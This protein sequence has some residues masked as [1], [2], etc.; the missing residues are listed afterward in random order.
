MDLIS[1]FY[2]D[3]FKI[4]ISNH[5]KIILYTQ[6][7]TYKCLHNNCFIKLVDLTEWKN[8]TQW[9]NFFILKNYLAETDFLCGKTHK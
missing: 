9:K 6:H 5:F 4:Y 8:E 2:V 3:N 7:S 1:Y